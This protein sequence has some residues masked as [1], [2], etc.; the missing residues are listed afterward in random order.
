MSFYIDPKSAQNYKL[1]T[2]MFFTKATI[3]EQTLDFENYDTSSYLSGYTKNV[4]KGIARE[5]L[6]SKDSPVYFQFKAGNTMNDPTL[7]KVCNIYNTDCYA[8]KVVP[9]IKSVS[10]SKGYTTGR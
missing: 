9:I 4:V 8:A 5:S 3:N 10:A 6:P 2:E 7:S 1:S